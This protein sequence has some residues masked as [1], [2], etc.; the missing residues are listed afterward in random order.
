MHL[1]EA[2]EGPEF[3]VMWKNEVVIFVLWKADI[4]SKLKHTSPAYSEMWIDWMPGRGFLLYTT[5]KVSFWFIPCFFNYR[6]WFIFLPFQNKDRDDK[7]VCATA[8]I[9]IQRHSALTSKPMQTTCRACQSLLLGKVCDENRS[10]MVT[11][12]APGSH[13]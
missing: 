1:H 8:Q 2:R 12:L 6:F 13:W 10:Q 3:P 11:C 4:A 9:L 5:L 7:R